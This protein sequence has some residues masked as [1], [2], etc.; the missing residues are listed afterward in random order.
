M[1]FNTF[2]FSDITCKMWQYCTNITPDQG[3]YIHIQHLLFSL[4][5]TSE[6]HSM[7]RLSL[8]HSSPQWKLELI[9]PKPHQ[10]KSFVQVTVLRSA[11][12][13]AMSKFA[14]R[15][16]TV[17]KHAQALPSYLNEYP[18]DPHLKIAHQG[19]NLQV[20]Y[21][22]KYHRKAGKSNLLLP[23][24]NLDLKT[25]FFRIRCCQFCDILL[26]LRKKYQKIFPQIKTAKTA[27]PP[28]LTNLQYFSSDVPMI[29]Y[30]RHLACLEDAVAKLNPMPS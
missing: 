12:K 11:S 26:F 21:P 29:W 27:F 16:V 18:Q 22:K 1:I 2:R 23:P 3:K 28:I 17:T 19:G 6:P 15:L 8:P 14:R 24:I 9:I 5:R 13:K 20:G 10:N 25:N 4:C 30:L 7:W